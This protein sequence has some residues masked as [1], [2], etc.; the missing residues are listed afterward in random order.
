MRA[1]G[2]LGIKSNKNVKMFMALEPND[3]YESSSRL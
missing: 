2:A 1:L 3:G